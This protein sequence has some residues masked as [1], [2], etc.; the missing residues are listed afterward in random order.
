MALFVV[1]LLL[2]F[3]SLGANAVEG[4]VNYP[5]W[6]HIPEGSFRPFHRH[7]NRVVPIW[8]VAPTML[9][10]LA[11]GLL[12]FFGPDTWSKWA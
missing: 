1:A 4:F 5:S 8:V 3:Y 12:I 2:G 10:T 6:H 7:L 9:W 11:T